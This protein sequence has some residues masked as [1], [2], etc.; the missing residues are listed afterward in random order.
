LNPETGVYHLL[1]QIGRI[2]VD[3]MERGS[4]LEEAVQAIQ[5]LTGADLRVI[6]EDA[7]AFLDDM[8]DRQLL[9]E[10]DDG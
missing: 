4:N 8:L 5:G 3:E 7:R 2:V 6:A 1:N 10:V 9:T